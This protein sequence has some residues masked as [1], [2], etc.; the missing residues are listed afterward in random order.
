[1]RFDIDSD[2]G[3][4]ISGWL[5]L[6]NP[7]SRPIFNIILPGKE[8]IQTV[9]TEFRQ[10]VLDHGFSTTGIVGFK[11]DDSIVP[12]IENEKILEIREA[13]SNLLL[14]RRADQTKFIQRKFL[15][16]D[17]SVSP[18]KDI[19]DSLSSFFATPYHFLDRYTFETLSYIIGVL[20]ESRVLYGKVNFMRHADMIKRSEFVV[21]ALVRDPFEELAER[22]I[23][24]KKAANHPN[25][26]FVSELFAS[27]LPVVD[28]AASLPIDDTK[29]IAKAF[30][31]LSTE[32][33]RVFCDPLTRML[34]CNIDEPASRHGV[35]QALENMSKMDVVGT[36]DKYVEF[37]AMTTGCFGAN[38]LGD[39]AYT[40]SPAVTDLAEKLANVGVVRDFLENDLALYSYINEAVEVG[41][42]AG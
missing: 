10:A 35:T 23:L 25:S 14:H 32:K 18:R 13:T 40:V 33:R 24:L 42:L 30:H 2:S 20:L 6:D 9:A 19:F 11:I 12:N 7:S 27:W 31:K 36:M 37:K 21:A 34:G 39:S 1:M 16:L 41:C 38:V 4:S 5:T 15:L 26:N 22:I 8:P 29:V 28:F 17:L 3:R